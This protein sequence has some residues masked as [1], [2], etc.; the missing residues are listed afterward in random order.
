VRD[1]L[2]VLAGLVI[3]TIVP[4]AAFGLPARWAAL[5]GLLGGFVIWYV[6]WGRHDLAAAIHRRREGPPRS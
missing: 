5:V 2:Y 6:L 1:F 3:G 4:A